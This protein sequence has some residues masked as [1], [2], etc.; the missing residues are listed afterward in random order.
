[1]SP[2]FS[3]GR[4]QVLTTARGRGRRAGGL[5]RGRHPSHGGAGVV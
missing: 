3:L 1:M 5:G 4:V 2:R